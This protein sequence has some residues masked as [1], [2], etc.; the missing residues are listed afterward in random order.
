V[1]RNVCW[2]IGWIALSMG[3]ATE[4]GDIVGGTPDSGHPAVALMFDSIAGIECPRSRS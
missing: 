1:K 2:L 4:A 3:L